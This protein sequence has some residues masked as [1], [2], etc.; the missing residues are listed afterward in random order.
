MTV[1]YPYLPPGR[2]ILYVP[3]DNPW[4]TA[5]ATAARDYSTE[6]NHPTGAVVVRQNKILGRGANQAAIKHAW[7]A[8]IHK[9]YFCVRRFFNIPSGQKYWLCP[10]CAQYRHHAEQR[11]VR[12]ALAQHSQ[13]VAGSDLYLWGHWWCCQPCWEAMLGAGIANV[14]LLTDSEILFNGT[15]GKN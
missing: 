14:Y 11:A 5:A 7:L 6:T 10:G 8:T 13:E 3:L 2:V 9:K 15:K 1:R 12:D 4:M